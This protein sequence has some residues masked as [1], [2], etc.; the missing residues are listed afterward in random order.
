MLAGRYARPPRTQDLSRRVALGAAGS[1]PPGATLYL[2]DEDLHVLHGDDGLYA[3]SGRCTHLGC[4]LKLQPEG[5]A[6]PCHGAHFDRLGRPV[7]GPAPR[8]LTGYHVSVDA[9]G[10]AWVHL[11]EIVPAGTAT[12]G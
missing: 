12:R 5:F 4:S 1:L 3:L 10:Q 8:P 9:A 6:C 2:P 7:S 11:D